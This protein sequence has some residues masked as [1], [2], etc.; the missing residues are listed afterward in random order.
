MPGNIQAGHLIHSATQPDDDIVPLLEIRIEQARCFT[1][2]A[3]AAITI[4]RLADLL[5]G[6]NGVAVP[7]RISL[8][9]GDAG[10]QRTTGRRLTTGA[11]PLNL[12]R[13]GNAITPFD[14]CCLSRSNKNGRPIA[15]AAKADLL[16]VLCELALVGNGQLVPTLPA[17]RRQDS[18]SAAGGHPLEEAM[19]TQ[20]RNPLWLICSLWHGVPNTPRRIRRG[21]TGKKPPLQAKQTST[22]KGGV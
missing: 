8:I 17:P 15:R 13:L 6:D 12:V 22:A 4:V 3:L 14:H 9:R 19:L 20:A 11:D 21:Q 2:Q 5:A 7:G 10:N 1:R 16:L 18:L